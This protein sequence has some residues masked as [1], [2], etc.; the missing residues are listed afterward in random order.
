[1]KKAYLLM[2]LAIL[3]WGFTGILGKAIQLNE[4]LI[5]WYRLLFTS[6]TLIPLVIYRKEFKNI[7]LRT[8]GRIF[9]VG[10][11]IAVHWILFY[12]AIKISNVSI[13]L[14]CFATVTLFTALLEPI[15]ERKRPQ[16][17]EIILA[18]MVLCGIALIYQVQQSSLWGIV[19]AIG[20]ALLGSLFTIE[21]KYLIRDIKPMY[22]TWLE[23]STGFIILS[24]LLPWYLSNNGVTFVFPSGMDLLYL[25]ILSFFCTTIAFS[26]SLIAL[27]TVS[28]FTMNLSV[29]LEPIYS[30]I[31]AIIIFDE[32]KELKSGFYL[33]TGIILVSVLLYSIE[34]FRKARKL[35]KRGVAQTA[36]PPVIG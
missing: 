30:I 12:L 15:Y 20:A 13:T 31:L 17:I 10:L 2:H 35:K 33:G 29:N 34:Q 14:S 21:N 32:G 3:L 6:L 24:I 18:L 9:F 27:E 1:M 4:S 5:V 8:L 19:A 25:F 36:T 23:I 11:L 16:S 22:L 7:P 26:I 28:A